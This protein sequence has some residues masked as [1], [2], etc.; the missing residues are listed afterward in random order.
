MCDNYSLINNR[1]A[2][3]KDKKKHLK[4]KKKILEVVFLFLFLFLLRNRLSSFYIIIY[5]S[6]A[7]Y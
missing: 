2:K 6:K 5:G 7:S 3:D 1:Q 4:K